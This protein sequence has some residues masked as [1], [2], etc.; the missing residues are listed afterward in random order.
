[1]PSRNDLFFRDH[2]FSQICFFLEKTTVSLGGVLHC[3][4]EAVIPDRFLLHFNCTFLELFNLKVLALQL[5]KTTAQVTAR[6]IK[7]NHNSKKQR[8]DNLVLPCQGCQSSPRPQ[9]EALITTL[10][11]S[12]ATL[13]YFPC[14]LLSM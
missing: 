5:R 10:Q 2:T 7:T 8:G 3:S 1:M 12:I 9:A 11:Q 4:E 14:L 6:N 13:T